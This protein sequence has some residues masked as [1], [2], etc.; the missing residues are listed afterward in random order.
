[1][2]KQSCQTK[3]WHRAVCVCMSPWGESHQSLIVVLSS[4]CT[5]ATM[6]APKQA[7]CATCDVPHSEG[8]FFMTGLHYTN[9]RGAS[10]APSIS[11]TCR[12]KTVTSTGLA[13]A[14][15]D[16]RDPVPESAYMTTNMQ[17]VMLLS[18]KF[19]LQMI[20]AQATATKIHDAQVE[21]HCHF[22]NQPVIDW[23]KQEGIH[24]TAYAPLSSPSTVS[25]MG[26]DLPNLL[27]VNQF[28]C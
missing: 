13:P 19:R 4:F 14:L 21:V 10:E 17:L 7:S 18:F 1:M 20:I 5:S 6:D 27:K 8:G 24:V 26:K 22:R 11:T 12:V 3:S 15:A 25:K 16:E 2:C 28:K 23:C 9:T